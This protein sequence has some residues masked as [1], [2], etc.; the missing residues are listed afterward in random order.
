[1]SDNVDKN[2]QKTETEIKLSEYLKPVE[3]DN[4]GNNSF[5]VYYM[6]SIDD[7]QLF[8]SRCGKEVS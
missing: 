2:Q 3:C 5:R 8:C 6:I 4:C 1:M 7:S